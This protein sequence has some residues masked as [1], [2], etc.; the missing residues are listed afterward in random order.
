MCIFMFLSQCQ[1]QETW[2]LNSLSLIQVPVSRFQCSIF[3]ISQP[4]VLL[5]LQAL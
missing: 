4:N 3:E 5:K 2:P 1:H